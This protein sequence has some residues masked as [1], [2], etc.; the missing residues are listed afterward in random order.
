MGTH[1]KITVKQLRDMVVSE[2]KKGASVRGGFVPKRP[3][4]PVIKLE[5]VEPLAHEAKLYQAIND[6]YAALNAKFGN[7]SEATHWL[8]K[9]CDD[10]VESEV[11]DW[12]QSPPRRGD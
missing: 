10:A 4:G 2:V 8:K 1:M 5:D 12:S 11:D 9:L 3:S 6:L 7:Q